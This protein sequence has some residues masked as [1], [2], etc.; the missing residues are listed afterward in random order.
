MAVLYVSYG[1]N[2]LRERFMAYITGGRFA[3]SSAAHPGCRDASPPRE[4][5]TLR[6]PYALHFARE[7]VHWGGGGVC[8]LDTA[9]RLVAC[10][11]CDDGGADTRS[12]VRLLSSA[13]AAASLA[14]CRA[15]AHTVG[16][17]Y[18]VTLAQ[19]NDVT[20]QECGGD[21]VAEV[22]EAALAAL[23]RRG[24]GASLLVGAAAAWYPLVVYL[25]DDPAGGRP[26]LTFTCAGGAAGELP[27]LHTPP[28]AAYATVVAAGLV[29]CVPSW[30]AD[31]A[32][33]YIASRAGGRRHS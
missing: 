29:Q 21:V 1:S 20:A 3:G 33:D 8:F 32:A 26:M 5:L 15:C 11:A 6:L 2:L 22:D 7:S 10:D 23:R 12:G 24:P 31:D 28:V 13:A 16:R 19:F 14:A 27:A 9:A 17:G 18:A 25:G 4:E 30:R